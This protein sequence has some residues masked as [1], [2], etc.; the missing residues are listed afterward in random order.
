MGIKLI[1]FNSMS[2][3]LRL[4][5]AILYSY[6]HF[7]CTCFLKGFFFKMKFNIQ[8][9]QLQKILNRSIWSIDGTSGQNRPESNDNEGVLQTPQISRTGILSSDAV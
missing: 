8:S 7:L 1:D 2:T 3:H 9:Y 6:L 5:H 4:F